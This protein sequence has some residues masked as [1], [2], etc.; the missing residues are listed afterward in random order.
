MEDKIRT[1]LNIAA[2][3]NHKV[4]ILS[5]F[6]CGAFK[7]P[8]R[9]VAQLFKSILD[10]PAYAGRFSEVYFSIKDDHNDTMGNY[11]SFREVFER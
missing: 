2:Y 9:H 11:Q 3:F 7:N 4:L 8:P 10:E 1:I 5:A 6:G